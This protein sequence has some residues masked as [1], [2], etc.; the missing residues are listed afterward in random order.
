MDIID[1]IRLGI[2]RA[3][4]EL[5]EIEMLA[6]SREILSPLT[7]SRRRDDAVARWNDLSTRLGW[8]SLRP[9]PSST[10]TCRCTKR[11]R[12]LKADG[13]PARGRPSVHRIV[14]FWRIPPEV[15]FDAD[16]HY[17]VRGK[18]SDGLRREEQ[19]PHD[20][21]GYFRACGLRQS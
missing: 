20:L 6:L 2:L 11:P 15:L 13:L 9:F 18:V 8:V 12:Q 19:D 1:E 4:L 14:G 3:R 5:C 10:V 16:A 17:V 7:N 21:A